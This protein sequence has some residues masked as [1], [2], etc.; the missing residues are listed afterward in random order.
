M[1]LYTAEEK[2]SLLQRINDNGHADLYEEKEM[3]IAKEL[4]QRGF[5]EKPIEQC[6][7]EHY[8]CQ[9]NISGREFLKGGGFTR[10]YKER[11]E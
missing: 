2:D 11:K 6:C 10:E 7:P 1:E 5:I 8:F 4:Y 3:N 9:S